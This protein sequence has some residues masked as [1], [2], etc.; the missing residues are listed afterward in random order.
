VRTAVAVF[1]LAN[2]DFYDPNSVLQKPK[3]YQAA[4]I[5]KKT[6]FVFMPLKINIC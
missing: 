5:E 6:S 1:F 3:K 2:H 4:P